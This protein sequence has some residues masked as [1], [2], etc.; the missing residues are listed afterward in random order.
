MIFKHAVRRRGGGDAAL[1]GGVASAAAASLEQIGLT[2]LEHLAGA[3]T[4]M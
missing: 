3:K 4:V 1:A 2:M